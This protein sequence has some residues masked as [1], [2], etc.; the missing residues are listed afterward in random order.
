MLELALMETFTRKLGGAGVLR[1]L[2]GEVSTTGTT[3]CYEIPEKIFVK[4]SSQPD[5]VSVECTLFDDSLEFDLDSV[6]D[7]L[8][9]LESSP[10]S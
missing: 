2:G 7:E 3:G 6:I 5:G 8:D 10:R 9:R 1:P 4:L